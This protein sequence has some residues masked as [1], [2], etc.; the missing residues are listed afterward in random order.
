V[1]ISLALGWR[2]IKV[3]RCL[4]SLP[5]IRV[6]GKRNYFGLTDDSPQAILW[7]PTTPFLGRNFDDSFRVAD[8]TPE[9]I[10]AANGTFVRLWDHDQPAGVRVAFPGILDLGERNTLGLNAQFAARCVVHH[11]LERLGEHVPRR[12]ACRS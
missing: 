6:R 2:A 4:E 8:N 7:L 12:N 1:Q 10:A 3:A 5:A 11:L 9:I